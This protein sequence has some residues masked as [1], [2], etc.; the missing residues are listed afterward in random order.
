MGE[1]AALLTSVCWAFCGIFFTSAGKKIGAFSVNLIRLTFAVILFFITHL[2][3]YKTFIPIH[4]TQSQ[5][6]WLALSGIIGLVIG[7][8]FLYQAFV[9]LDVRIPMLVMASV[10]MISTLF[11]W[12]FLNEN[13]H[14]IALFGILITIIGIILVINDRRVP[15]KNKTPIDRKRY[16]LGILFAFGG[17]LGQAGGLIFAKFGLQNDLPVL[18]ATLMRMLPSLAAILILA[19]FQGKIKHTISIVKNNPKSLANIFYGSIIGPFVGVWL[20][21]IAV[22]SAYV[23][24]ASTL[25]ALAPVVLLPISKWF[26]KENIS[27]ASVIG[28]FL[29]IIGVAIIFAG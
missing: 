28:T 4:A 12:I 26:Y 17:A 13:L 10:P 21:L 22:Q 1:I 2:L 16:A 11:A 23:G 20:S 25:M 27:R 19:L 24:T 29:T 7:D 9:Y 15:A 3:I 6:L 5:W 18:S 14:L 8:S